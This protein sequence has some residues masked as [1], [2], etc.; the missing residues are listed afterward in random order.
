M[1]NSDLIRL[2]TITDELEIRVRNLESKKL[3]KEE[4]ITIE[5]S[6]ENL[7]FKPTNGDKLFKFVSNT[8]SYVALNLEVES[9][10]TFNS[11]CEI[12]VNDTL[13]KQY[14]ISF[15]FSCEVPI[16]AKAGENVVKIA[17]YT[18]AAS[19]TF[20]VDAK[21]SITGNVKVKEENVKLGAL[22]EGMIYLKKGDV[23]K[24]ID[25][26][27]M[28]TVACYTGREDVCVGFLRDNYMLFTIKE[29]DTVK[30]QRHERRSNNCY[31]TDTVELE[32]KQADVEVFNGITSVYVIRGE[33]VYMHAFNANGSYVNN[34]PFKAKKVF[35]F[36]GNTGR[37]IYLVDV[38]GNCT[39]VKHNSH[40]DFREEKRVS[41]GKLINANLSE[42][43]G[44]L[45]VLYKQG[46]VVVKRPVFEESLP[47]AVGV[48]DE[49]VIT[50][51]GVT[52]IR[53]KDKIIKL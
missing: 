12:Y 25:S 24:T 27:T 43:N 14:N 48:G 4:M 46:L 23:V 40:V 35:V 7:L 53:K 33:N 47:E 3:N 32:Y 30:L 1:N 49:G 37:Y 50:D 11:Q 15:P 26:N 42:E 45:V 21:I 38:R 5:E 44:K 36:N 2:N 31:R 13:V 9:T 39:V 51:E 18:N 17:I 10:A 52:I 34:L 22:V 6:S 20:K 8:D 41:L 28:E 16:R 29:G 19:A